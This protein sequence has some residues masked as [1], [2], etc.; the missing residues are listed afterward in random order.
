MDLRVGQPQWLQKAEW[1]ICLGATLAA[2]LLHV[3]FL[4]HAGALWRDEVNG[5][6]L[7]TL[8]SPSQMWHMLRYDSFPAL[9]P[10]LVRC[11]AAIGL[12][13]SDFALR[14]LGFLIGL[15]LLGAVWLNARAFR[16][17]LPL[18]SLGLLAVNMTLVRSGDS[19]RGYGVGCLFILLSLAMIWS[20]M[21]APS[22]ERFLGATLAAILSVHCLYQ[23]AFL[24][25]AICV[26]GCFV[27]FRHDQL[28][29]ALA[30]L[31]VGATAAF[32]LLP[33]IGILRFSE[34]WRVVQ[35]SGVSAESAWLSL[36]GALGDPLVMQVPFWIALGLTA[37]VRGLIELGGR[38][39]KRPIGA[40]DLPLFAGLIIAI[41]GLLFTIC[42][43]MAKLPTKPW[44]WLPLMVVAAVCIEASLGD[45]FLRCRGW[46]L[47]LVALLVFVPLVPSIRLAS[48]RPTNVDLIAAQLHEQAR[49]GDLILV[50]PWYCG[51]SFS[52]YYHGEAPWTTLPAL[53]EN[54]IHRYDLFKQKMAER[55]P[56]QP[57]LDRAAQTLAAGNRLWIVGNLP[58]PRAGDTQ[59]PDLPPAPEGP[60]GWFDVP[61]SYTW[62]R[63]LDFFLALQGGKVEP[64]PTSSD[65][66]LNTYEKL[67]FGVVRGVSQR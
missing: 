36:T 42:I 67:S 14:G 39:R 9:F 50:Y 63:Q 25:F 49:P 15:A 20:L 16:Y 48:L 17:R 29:T 53:A 21:V 2:V 38:P 27:C 51:V 5:V 35:Q 41:G 44:Y 7:A 43:L 62:G 10:A 22:L 23:N 60:Q 1:G 65:G 24:L 13:K 59:P 18:V 26:A 57:V 61:Y 58:P 64:I 47:A 34:H 19:L 45:W 28:K 8:F 37:A 31:S 11:W 40:S 33:Y 52:R 4:T 46:R 30:L 12:G 66:V 56:I 6:H 3:V 32:S 55:A 54:R